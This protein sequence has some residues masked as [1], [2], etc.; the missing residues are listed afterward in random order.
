MGILDDIY[1][2]GKALLYGVRDGVSSIFQWAAGGINTAFNT[3]AST[4]KSV[5]NWAWKGF[6]AVWSGIKSG[7]TGLGTVLKQI[8]EWFLNGLK[9]IYNELGKLMKVL[10][11]VTES[12]MMKYARW[13]VKLQ[14]QLEKEIAGG[15]G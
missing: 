9:T 2:T 5:V 11:E 14:M 6:D 1:N 3:I 10:F 4:V 15:C 7:I 13:Q 12:V 8:Y